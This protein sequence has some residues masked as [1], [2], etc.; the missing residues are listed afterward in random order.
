M[1]TQV[2]RCALAV[3]G[4][5]VTL[6]ASTPRVEAQSPPQPATWE[7]RFTSGGLFPTGVARDV[8]K[9]AMMSA[10][11]VSYLVRPAVAIT[12]TLGWAESH[13]LASVDAP[14]L[15]VF[16]YDLGIEARAHQWFA[17]HAVTFNP[18]VGAGAGGR[19]YNYRKL[20]FDATHNV[21]GYGA[22]GGEIGIRRVHVRLELRDYVTG[23]KPLQGV[24]GADTRNDVV[25]MVGLR[26]TKH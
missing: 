6:L 1:D 21:A 5:L 10:A 20:D 26:F 24:G 25:A 8:L 18:F 16:S 7:I 13:D 15:D 17:G 23:F 19:S 12:A 9:D 14:K 11:Q 4:A 2:S 22:V 3:A